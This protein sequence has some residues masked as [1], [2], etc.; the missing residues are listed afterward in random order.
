ML[1]Q[2]TEHT[3]SKPEEKRKSMIRKV[4]VKN[5]FVSMFDPKTGFYM[6]SGIIENGKDTGV[7]PFMTSFPELIDVG[8]MGW[9]CHGVSGLCM[10]SGVQCYQD[11]LHTKA[12]NMSLENFKRIVD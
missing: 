3:I 10:K 12:E 9:C 8:V 6:R 11:G 7:D 5:K 1:L 2:L 4:D